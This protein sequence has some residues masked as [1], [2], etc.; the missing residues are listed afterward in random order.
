MRRQIGLAAAAVLTGQGAFA[1]D[2]APDGVQVS[3]SAAVYSD[4]LYRGIS[5]TGNDAAVQGSIGTSYKGFS[6]SVWASNVSYADAEVDFTASYGF[7]RGRSSFTVGS[8][9]YAYPH[10]AAPDTD[11]WEGFATW[12]APIRAATVGLGVYVSPDFTLNSGL[13][14]YAQ[15]AASIPLVD[16]LSLNLQGGR[17]WIDENLTAGLPDYWRW[18]AGLAYDFDPV[19]ISVA[20]EDTDISELLCSGAICGPQVVAGVAANF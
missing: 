14:V 5:Q 6:A 13:A 4:Y 15:A 10:A 9:Y 7:T 16:R 18:S 2:P 11:Y 12:S 19:S 17:Q 3:A 20:Y 1:Q 8:I